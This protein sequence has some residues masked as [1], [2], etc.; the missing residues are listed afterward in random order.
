VDTDKDGLPNFIDL[1]S[2]NDGI[3][4]RIEGSLDFDKDGKGNFIDTDSDN[5]G[6]PDAIEGIGDPDNDGNPNYLDLDSDGDG[7]SDKLEGTRDSDN[8]GV[9]NFLDQDSDN[10]G[11]PDSV[12]GI[13]DT[14]G[15]GIPNYRDEDSDND[16]I[17]DRI[18]AGPDPRNPIDT[19]NDGKPDY[20]DTDSDE[21]GIPDK[22]E[23]PANYSKYP[24]DM[25]PNIAGAPQTEIN[26]TAPVETPAPT[27]KPK[28]I[29]NVSGGSQQNAGN[30]ETKFV[31]G[32]VYRVQV[33]MSLKPQSE[34]KFLAMGLKDIYMYRS[35]QYYK[36]CAGAFKTE[37][38]A[39]AHKNVL[40]A[41][42]FKD[43]FVAK[44]DDG[45]RVM[46]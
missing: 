11:I 32:V 15:D 1:D 20:I 22:F 26:Q 34:N 14:D 30:T 17:P 19:D 21:D 44:F 29:E 24:K 5:D 27:P 41:K 4:D 7:I 31:P 46:K 39:E 2:D 36:Y 25:V 3:P 16:G 12:E 13:K 38:E 6:I 10:D 8:D 28:T 18:E 40:R 33:K 35:G 37:E 45:V 9:M 42:G 43:A 23:A